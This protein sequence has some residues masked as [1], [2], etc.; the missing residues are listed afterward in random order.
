MNEV[1]LKSG[2]TCRDCINHWGTPDNDKGRKAFCGGIEAVVELDHYPP[3]G[4]K[5]KQV[6]NEEGDINETPLDW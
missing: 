1:N 4:G 6:I 5:L 3:C 2:L